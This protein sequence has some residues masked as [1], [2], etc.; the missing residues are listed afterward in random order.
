[1]VASYAKCQS[2]RYIYF[3]S[4]VLLKKLIVA[5]I[6][7]KFPVF[8]QDFLSHWQRPY[9]VLYPEQSTH[10]VSYVVDNLTPYTVVSSEFMILKCINFFLFQTC[11]VSCFYFSWVIKIFHSNFIEVVCLN[12]K[13][14]FTPFTST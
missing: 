5:L 9:T 7:K 10:I 14:N 12:S 2:S 6:L 11:C 8:Y 4:S 1:M 3:F 13:Q